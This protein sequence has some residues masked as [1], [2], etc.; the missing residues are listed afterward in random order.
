MVFVA[1]QFWFHSQDI[2]RIVLYLKSVRRR[3]SYWKI[4][5]NIYL[6]TVISR[7]SIKNLCCYHA[8]T[9]ATSPLMPYRHRYILDIYLFSAQYKVYG[10]HKMLVRIKQDS[11]LKNNYEQIWINVHDVYIF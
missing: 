7:I 9:T 4:N 6:T 11:N 2:V 5:F 3:P 1:Q 10:L 8:S